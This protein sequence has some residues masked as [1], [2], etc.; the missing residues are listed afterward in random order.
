MRRFFVLLIAGLS[1]SSSIHAD[2]TGAGDIKIVAELI[3]IYKTANETLQTLK[4]QNE[5]IQEIKALARDATVV[6]DTLSN[7]SMD[8]LELRIR[9]DFESLTNLDDLEGLSLR[10]K[11]DVLNDELDRRV[12]DALPSQKTILEKTVGRQK[13][14]LKRYDTL[15]QL[16]AALDENLV[17]ARVDIDERTAAQIQAQSSTIDATLSLIAAQRQLDQT[18]SQEVDRARLELMEEQHQGVYRAL[19]NGAW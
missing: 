12:E 19:S 10:E 14:L 11:I 2:M 4:T 8:D 5:N 7:F 18:Q 13:A 17:E 3:K 6:Y 16:Q 15:A 9:R 1:F